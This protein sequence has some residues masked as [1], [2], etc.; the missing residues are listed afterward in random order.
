M[1]FFLLFALFISSIHAATPT[2]YDF[3]LGPIGGTFRIVTGDNFARVSGVTT[4]G[5]GEAAGLQVGD[6]IYGSDGVPFDNNGSDFQGVTRQ[7]GWAI[8]QAQATDG[9]LSLNVLRAETGL[10]TVDIALGTAGGFSPAFPLN[11][12]TF[13][14]VAEK[15]LDTLNQRLTDSSHIGYPTGFAGIALLASPH[16]NDS[17]G[18]HP[19]RNGI[20]TVYANA[21]D[22]IERAQY[23]PVEQRHFDGTDNPHYDGSSVIYLENWYLGLGTMFLAEYYTKTLESP[24]T[25]QNIDDL[26]LLQSA[27]EK[28]ANRIQWWRQPQSNNA[29]QYYTSLRPGIVGHGNVS[30]DYMHYGWGGGINIV[31]VHMSGGLAMAKN[32]GVDM[33]VR[34]LDGR[35]FGYDPLLFDGDATNDPAGESLPPGLNYDHANNTVQVRTGVDGNGD[36]IWEAKQ[37]IPDA[38]S[39]ADIPNVATFATQQ[40]TLDD[41]LNIIWDFYK[42]SQSTGTGHIN[43]YIDSGS[44]GDSGGRT[45]GVLF[46]THQMQQSGAFTGTNLDRF[47]LLKGY[48]NEQ[49]DRHLNAHA[50][51]SPGPNFYALAASA[52]DTRER[53]HFYDNWRFFY[54]LSRNADDTTTFFR[55]RPYGGPGESSQAD[56]IYFALN[57]GVAAGGLTLVQGYDT[58]NQRLI[59]F[60]KVPH[61]QWDDLA[62]RTLSTDQSSIDL[63]LEVTDG[64]GAPTASYT[65]AWTTSSTATFTSASTAD[66]TINFPTPGTY[67]VT[68]TITDGSITTT[69]PIRIEVL[70]SV[71]ESLYS[72]GVA[73]YDV[74]RSING[75]NLAELYA[76][77]KWPN[78]PDESSQVTQLKGT[79]TGNNFGA[80]LTTTIIPAETGTYRFYLSSDDQG[81]LLFNSSGADSAG[82]AEIASVS[83]W[84]ASGQWDK[85]PEQESIEFTLTAGQ[86]YY[87]E[88]R[89][90]EG[91]GDQPFEIAWITPSNTNIEII[92]SGFIAA[93]K[94]VAP[95]AIT[96]QPQ[97]ITTTLG[98]AITLT[99]EV[100][101]PEPRLFQWKKDGVNYSTPSTLPTLELANSSAYLAGDW[102]LTYTSGNTV[103]ISDIA[104]I[105]FSDIGQLVTG[106]LWQEVYNGISGIPLDNLLNSAK[107]PTAPDSSG[108]I[109]VSYQGSLGDNY[110]QRWTGWI[111]PSETAR[112]RFYGAADDQIAIN[113]SPSEFACHAEQIFFSSSYTG[114][115]NYDQRSPSAWVD[116]VAG[117]R[118]FIEVLHKEGGGGDHASISWQKEGDPTPV[119]G[120]EGIPAA[121]LQ[122][123]TGGA[124]PA[125]ACPPFAHLTLRMYFPLDEASGTEADDA[126]VFDRTGPVTGGAVMGV[127]GK[128]GKA[129]TMD[130]VDDYITASDLNVNSDEVTLTAW[131]KRP[132]ADQNGTAGIIFNRSQN[133]A[134]LNF[135]A[136]NALRYHWDG[137]NW[138]LSSGLVPTAD[139]WVFVALVVKPDRATIYMHDGTLQQWTNVGGHGSQSFGGTT[140][141]GRDPSNSS[142]SF[143][144]DLDE[145]RVYSRALSQ[146]E[147]LS[148]VAGGAAQ[149]PSPFDGAVGVQTP[150][151]GWVSASAATSYGVYLGTTE[152]AVTS[153]NTGSPEY[154]GSTSTADWEFPLQPS[155]VYY[156]RVDTVTGSG[157]IAGE[158]WEFTTGSEIFET[159]L[160]AHWKMN[161]GSGTTAL[162]ST[163]NNNDATVNGASW[164]SGFEAGGLAFDGD[165]D[166]VTAGTGPS[167]SGQ[168]NLTLTAWV[169]TSA[170]SD[171]VIIQQR[172]GG[173]NGQYQLKV[174]ANGTVGFFLYGN[175]AYQFNFSTT[176]TVNDGQW[177][178][179]SAIRSGENG[180]IYLDGNP[181]PAASA[182]GIIRDLSASIGVGIGRDIRDNDEPF[183]G[184]IDEVKIYEFGKSGDE[185]ATMYNDYLKADPYDTWAS[186]FDLDPTT[187]GAPT[188]DPDGDGQN[189]LFEFIAGVLPNDALSRFHWRVEEDPLNSG[190]SRIV[191]SPRFGDRT[192][193]LKTSTTLQASDWID[194]TGGSVIDDGDERTVIDPDTSDASKFYRLEIAKP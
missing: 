83:G 87:L 93:P 88:A 124:D 85:Y 144:G 114:E 95:I 151:A 14:A 192:Y 111:V 179:I 138:H 142:R 104:T 125:Q 170:S 38:T 165:N 177:H 167:L 105:S 171:Q 94:V 20:D 24:P 44:L 8:G 160:I 19:Y 71:D 140:Y 46:T 110:G 16:W 134:G 23:S 181:S 32:A 113:L 133:A 183:N 7:L 75:T 82:A 188:A 25:Q 79:A 146:A 191:F 80:R 129:V 53:Q 190:Q 90:K 97:S 39:H 9:T 1:K 27:A 184:S 57:Q 92:S 109:N 161:S 108:P 30:G 12:P 189:N 172:D 98:E 119:D 68:L 115:K 175:N 89:M 61:L 28:L 77:A 164:T 126:S 63:D 72:P 127:A 141:I 148:L 64:S 66:T 156:W 187:N 13:D 31:G 194:F 128:F 70:P 99:A 11:S 10:T 159:G 178:F 4:G 51:N 116:L 47:N 121:N 56:E 26:A 73:N 45:P 122:Y 168:T 62:H 55:G 130:G 150:G 86:H 6:F 91:S 100:T 2:D 135:G 107:Y 18:A 106:G 180:A 49:Y 182:N 52:I 22:Q 54:Q 152:S 149:S 174:N 173:F 50:M 78:S 36:P 37:F 33:T 40:P 117:R 84:T 193:N 15:S 101:G 65:A 60:Q 21:K 17:T 185:V 157:T 186:S 29:D 34:P 139:Q 153:A 158:V 163:P 43:Y 67:D 81:S 123:R 69:E 42:R 162:D 74:F 118:Y 154:Q 3:P 96:T 5:F 112:Y 137:R 76:D 143:T 35:Y 102:Q 59:D 120:S 136:G 145:P 58:T 155:T 48:F 103:L 176:T 132:A 166:F 169:K 147:I 131:I 41:K